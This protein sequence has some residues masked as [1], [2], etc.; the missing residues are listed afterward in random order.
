[1]QNLSTASLFAGSVCYA[2]DLVLLAPSPSALMIMLHC[3]EDF[4]TRVSN[5]YSD[6]RYNR[7]R[8]RRAYKLPEVGEDFR[9]Q[10]THFALRVPI[11]VFLNACFLEL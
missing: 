5:V 9:R 8:L 11:L 7:T 10:C 1:M 6:N 2:D 3:C 4:A